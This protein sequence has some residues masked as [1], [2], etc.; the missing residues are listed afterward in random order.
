VAIPTASSWPSNGF[1]FCDEFGNKVYQPNVS[2]VDIHGNLLHEED[3]SR[4]PADTQ[5]PGYV[6]CDELLGDL[7]FELNASGFETW[8]SCQEPYYSEQAVVWF[9]PGMPVRG[10]LT[11]RLAFAARRVGRSLPELE[12]QD[13]DVGGEEGFYIDHHDI[14]LI[15][16]LLRL[17]RTADGSL[18]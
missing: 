18:P 16:G 9:F 14:E 13:P 5:M 8:E 7:V 12:W 6:V 17:S 4:V 2:I 3:A 15:V 10:R 11:R 1:I